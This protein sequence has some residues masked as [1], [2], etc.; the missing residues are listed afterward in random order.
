MKPFY[1]TAG[2][3]FFCLFVLNT[4]SQHHPGK[5]Q[6]FSFVFMTDLHV[7]HD[8]FVVSEFSRLIDTINKMNV[9]FVLTG[10]DQVF[11]VMRG[12]V[13][14]GDSL[15]SLYKE[16]KAKIN[17]PVHMQGNHELFGIYLKVILTL[18]IRIISMDAYAI[19]VT[20]LLFIMKA[21]I[22]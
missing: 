20:V 5:E 10:G 14:K 9:D 18:L 22:L 8:P 11:D 16:L 15:F 3:L 4:F 17:V 21:C 13:K 7:K 6:E 12:N 19:S 1:R 2:V